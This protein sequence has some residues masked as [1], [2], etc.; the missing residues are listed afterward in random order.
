MEVTPEASSGGSRSFAEIGFA[1]VLVAVS[2]A[3]IATARTY[4]AESAAYPI[5]IGIGMAV[6][7]CWIGLREILRRRRGNPLPGGFAEH[8]PRL[9]IGVAA[10][11][12]YFAAVSLIGFILPSL[13]LCILLPAA[14][15]FRRWSLSAI[16]AVVCVATILAIFVYALG[17][18]IP[19]DILSPF[20]GWLR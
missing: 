16:V 2:I 3:V 7:G 1:I 20:L 14:A 6:L 15:G 9:A 5:A 8:A 11:V 19:P 4:P 12:I 10:L 18:P 13:A 17:R